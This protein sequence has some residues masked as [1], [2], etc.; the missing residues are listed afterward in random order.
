MAGMAWRSVAWQ[1]AAGQG[2]HGRHGQD[3][4]GMARL[5][6][7]HHGRLGMDRPGSDGLGEA[8]RGKAFHRRHTDAGEIALTGDVRPKRESITQGDS[9]P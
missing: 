2:R 1:G 9:T 5:G 8:R 4:R 6:E 3:W 7:A